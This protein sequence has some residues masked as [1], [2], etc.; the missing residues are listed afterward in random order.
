MGRGEPKVKIQ[1]IL[2]A[3]SVA[4]VLVGA[5]AANAAL[6]TFNPNSPGTVTETSPFGALAIGGALADNYI[7]YG[8][9]FTFG[10]TEGYFNDGD[11]Y[12]FCGINNAGDCDLL[13]DVDGRIVQVGTHNQG[14]TD[15]LYAEAGYSSDGSLTLSVFDINNVLLSSVT[16][17]NPLGTYGRTTFS[18]ATAGIAS[19]RISGGDTY[20]VNEIRLNTPS[21]AVPEPATWGLMIMGFGLS[22][23]ALRSRRRMAIAAV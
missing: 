7:G 17:G 2:A 15:Y 4:A 12:G 19:F 1:N 14:T 10:N 23:V 5:G 13:T 21:G 9:D 8:V 11:A 22:G 18:I 20:G 3:A 6:I 16:N